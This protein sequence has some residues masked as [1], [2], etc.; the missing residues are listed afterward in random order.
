[1]I[2]VAALIAP[3]EGDAPAGESLQYSGVYD[4]IREARRSEDSLAQGDWQRDTKV[5]DWHTVIELATDALAT[6]TK[7]LQIGAWLA[8]ALIEIHGFTGLRD[9]LACH[10]R[11]ARI[12]LGRLIPG[13]DDGDLEGRGNSL[14][15]MDRQTGGRA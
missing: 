12:F 9:A 6:R 3:L 1:V 5:A 11:Y 8:E 7:D 10:R 14:A 2:D 13:G 15:W 4:E